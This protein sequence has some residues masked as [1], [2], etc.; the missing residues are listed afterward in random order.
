MKEIDTDGVRIVRIF[1]FPFQ[2]EIA[3]FLVAPL[4]DGFLAAVERDAGQFG[5]EG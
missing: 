1:G 4:V 3:D 5:L 2:A